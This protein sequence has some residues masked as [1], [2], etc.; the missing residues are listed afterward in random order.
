MLG[1][2]LID[3]NIVFSLLL[4]QNSYEE[5]E[6]LFDAIEHLS[7]KVQILD[8]ALYSATLNFLKRG[9]H[10]EIKQFLE[11]LNS[12]KNIFIYRPKPSEISAA[13]SL[14]VSLDFDDKLHYYLAKKKNLT[15]VSYDRDFD[16]TDLKRLTPAQALERLRL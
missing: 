3:S 8:F 13:L 6:R 5:T 2:M 14:K 10:Q 1:T 9:H 4:E 7:L 11:T 12:S 16:K 15:L